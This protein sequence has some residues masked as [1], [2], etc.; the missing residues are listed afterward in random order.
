[1]S[2]KLLTT[3]AGMSTKL[4]VLAESELG[5]VGSLCLVKRKVSFLIGASASLLIHRLLG[6]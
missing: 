1:M 5:H 4:D 2:L 6:Q 3:L